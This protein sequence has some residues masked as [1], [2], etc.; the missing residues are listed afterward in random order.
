MFI[1]H[2]KIIRFL[3]RA[4]ERSALSHAYIF[5]GPV[6]LGKFTLAQKLA[7][8]FTR[9]QKEA[10]PDLYIARPE[11]EEIKNK[12]RKK[13][14]SVEQIRQLGQFLSRTSS[15]GH[16]KIAI[17]DE[18]DR[19]TIGAQNAILKTLEEPPAKVMLFLIAENE[20]KLLRTIR[21]RCQTKRFNPVSA[22]MISKMVPD[23]LKEKDEIIFWSLGRPGLA[24]KMMDD[25]RE[26][27]IR[28][29][30]AEIFSK[31]ESMNLS[32][33]FDLAEK[34]S[35]NTQEMLET[36]GFW[37]ILA[38]ETMMA[39]IFEKAS[40]MSDISEKIGESVG[41]LKTTNSNPRLVLENLFL[42]I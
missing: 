42:E 19:M 20:K 4:K 8:D 40:S 22:V 28:R 7:R 34:M 33:K 9:C 5:S 31:L 11:I 3:E 18:A 14:I 25:S 26:L 2:Q 27:A 6:S 30:S 29:Q 12:I 16:M 21:S 38:R 36:L 37:S 1:G 17:I 10:N 15:G 24:R 39:S 41:I 35:K 13:D 32:E 23:E